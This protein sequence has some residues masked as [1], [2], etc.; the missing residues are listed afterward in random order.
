MEA[1]KREAAKRRRT[2]SELVEFALR[3][4]LRSQKD[5]R[6]FPRLPTFR[7]GGHLVDIVDRDALY[8]AMERH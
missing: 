2:M 7:S 4:F 8:Q 5:R 1:L 3:L 6:E